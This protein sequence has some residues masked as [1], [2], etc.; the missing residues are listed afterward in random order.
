MAIEAT[1]D[2]P[3]ESPEAPEA[4]PLEA[5][6][7]ATDDQIEAPE[8]VTPEATV[9]SLA[10][11]MGWKPKD[12]FQ[13]DDET[14][15]DAA[16]Y[17]RKGEDIKESM[18]MHLKDN[19]R[20]MTALERGIDDLKVHNDQVFKVTLAKQQREIEELRSQ[21][22]EAIEEGDAD[23]V[24]QIEG[25]MLEKYNTMEE[26]AK[27]PPEPPTPKEEDVSAFDG[28][29]NTNPW[30]NVK[31]SNGGDTDMTT[32]ADRM[33][34]LPEYA[35]LPYDRKL[36]SVTQLVKKA[37][38]EKFKAE[39]GRTPSANAVEA[40]RGVISKK[41]FS[42]RDLSTDQKAIMSNFVKRGIMTEKQYIADLAS[43]GEVG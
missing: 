41:Q 32:Y 38:P 6:V 39:P 37:F 36:A 11:D 31:G 33:A 13:G 4:P 42:S 17:I 40:P 29:R 1:F 22:R 30:Y 34:E 24:D 23:K 14:Y 25:Q 8:D 27:R 43:I 35:A 9:E 28:W 7:E 12:N 2:E 20:K 15:V 16:T 10:T 19:R 21:K 18:R 26:P 5:A 3:T